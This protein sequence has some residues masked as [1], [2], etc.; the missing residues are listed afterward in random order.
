MV[1]E[2]YLPWVGFSIEDL[3]DK[4]HRVVL[5]E[6]DEFDKRVIHHQ[7]IRIFFRAALLRG[8]GLGGGVAHGDMCLGATAAAPAAASKGGGHRAG[9]SHDHGQRLA[10]S[11]RPA[12]A[13]G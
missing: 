13:C 1:E 4:Q 6:L 3:S 5:V 11:K 7:I 2:I 12:T 9:A 8:G 10:A